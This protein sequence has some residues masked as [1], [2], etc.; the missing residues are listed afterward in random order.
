MPDISRSAPV[1][2][3]D[4]HEAPAHDGRW[5]LP[6]SHHGAFG[7]GG[8]AHGAAYPGYGA[9]GRGQTAEPLPPDPVEDTV[10]V[11]GLDWGKLN[12]DARAAVHHLLA[13][14]DEAHDQLHILRGRADILEQT[15]HCLPS[16]PVL[17]APAFW[18]EFEQFLQQVRERR[19]LGSLVLLVQTNLQD[20]LRTDGFLAT[21]RHLRATATSLANG[22][23]QSD[24]IGLLTGGLFALLLVEA[25]LP[26]AMRKMDQLLAALPHPSDAAPPTFLFAARPLSAKDTA[27]E[28]FNETE[29]LLRHRWQRAI[30]RGS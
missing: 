7:H 3:S 20:Y 18:H 19:A 22:L 13:E 15:A 28:A 26:Q 16:Y 11:H 17:H 24:R 14:L 27:V 10:S 6:S 23:R 5:P 4:W 21:D 2:A 9:D 30:V 25:D 1:Q 12:P 8:S 29:G